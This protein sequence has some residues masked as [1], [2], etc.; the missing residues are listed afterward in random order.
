MRIRVK[1]GYFIPDLE[2]P[3]EAHIELTNECNLNCTICYRRWF[4]RSGFMDPNLFEKIL[5]ELKDMGVKSVWFDGFGEPTFHP[6]FE[7]FS[8]MASR[9][10]ELNLVTNGTIIGSKLKC[11]SENFKN[12]FVSLEASDPL[13]YSR[14]RGFE[15]EKL[16]DTLRSLVKEGARVWVSTVLLKGTYEA[17][18]SLVKWA[19]ELGIKGILTS[20]LIPT[21]EK[22][23]EEK[24]YGRVEVDHISD[25]MREAWILA[26][27]SNMKLLAPSFYYRSDRWCPFVEGDSLAITYEGD[28]SPCLFAL[29]DYRAWIEGKEV[30][31]KQISFGNLRERSL[32]E[33]WFSEDYV[34]FRSFVKLS[35]Y[36]SCHDCPAWE[37][38]QI[39][40]SNEYDCWGNSPSCSFCPYYRG[41][42]RCPTGHAVRGL[43]S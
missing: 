29:H 32:R 12:V 25:I 24:L 4:E 41:V 23:S 31:V 16:N 34:T 5:S 38:C 13:L 37:G 2:A 30:Q 39:S 26:T 28:V 6:K 36:P 27:S 18:P 15:F 42:V 40:E 14:V 10:F 22:M 3:K 7:E 9:D 17:L 21:S 43:L 1:G 35:N 33:I 8:N 20:N 11:I 19:S